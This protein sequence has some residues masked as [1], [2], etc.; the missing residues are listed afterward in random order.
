MKK[1]ADLNTRAK[2]IV[3]QIAA[4]G[5]DQPQDLP[6]ISN[7]TMRQVMAAMG[8]KGGL[9]GGKARAESMTP[10]KRKAI[11]QLAAAA[12]W[13]GSAGNPH[14]R[15]EDRQRLNSLRGVG[16]WNARVNAI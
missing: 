2:S 3:D 14:R 7:E 8:R 4:Q 11:A 13:G 10:A 16:G 15:I 1:P 6:P 12:R 9:K 5:T